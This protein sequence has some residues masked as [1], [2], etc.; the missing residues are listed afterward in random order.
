MRYGAW[1]TNHLKD[2]QINRYENRLRLYVHLML[3]FLQVMRLVGEGYRLPPPPGCPK[4]IYS[5]MIKCW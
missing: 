5:L 3:A 1:D 4:A 2:T